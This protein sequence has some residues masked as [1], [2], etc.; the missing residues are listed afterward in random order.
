MKQGASLAVP[1]SVAEGTVRLL[2]TTLAQHRRQEAVLSESPRAI[3][4]LHALPT[5]SASSEVRRQAALFRLVSIVEAFVA[6]GL[7]ERLE[8][9]APPPRT[10]ILEDVYSRAEDGAISSWPK[11]REHYKQW[12]QIGMVQ[13]PVWRKVEA[14]TNAR[15]VIAHGVGELTR[16][17]A[18]RDPANLRRD[19]AT[20][21]V[22]ISGSS[23]RVPESAV[24]A[25]AFA[26]RDFVVWLDSALLQYDL[27]TAQGAI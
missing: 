24:S 3:G 19:L 6:G 10:P 18:R 21:D 17:M 13:C 22:S 14:M 23:L 16:R 26:G 1:S 27:R 2:M 5:S 9:H 4:R 20:I 8:P 11:M 12:F 7:V 15:N 25:S